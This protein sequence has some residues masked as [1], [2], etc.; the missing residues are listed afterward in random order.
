MSHLEITQSFSTM[1]EFNPPID[2]IDL[3]K[4]YRSKIQTSGSNIDTINYILKNSFEKKYQKLCDTGDLKYAEMVI[5]DPT[6]YPTSYPAFV[7]RQIKWSFFDFDNFRD[8]NELM[9]KLQ[10][11][12][13]NCFVPKRFKDKKTKFS[14][15][16]SNKG[17]EH[18]PL[19]HKCSCA[20]CSWD[21]TRKPRAQR[22]L[23]VKRSVRTEDK[24]H[25]WY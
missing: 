9:K 21:K 20:M 23:K 25:R 8:K 2:T 11:V 22:R 24:Y 19:M 16:R 13:Q 3:L 10:D 6:K 15:L 7:A 14:K 18:I 17:T 4:K 12:E 5:D 1:T